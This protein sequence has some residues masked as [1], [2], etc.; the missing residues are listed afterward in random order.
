MSRGEYIYISSEYSYP[1]VSIVEH[2][3]TAVVTFVDYI[4]TSA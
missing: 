3:V 2:V 4:L 1:S